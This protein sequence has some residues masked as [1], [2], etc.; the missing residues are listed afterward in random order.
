MLHEDLVEYVRALRAAGTDLAQVEAKRAERELPKSVR[1]TLSAFSNTPGGG[2]LILGLDEAEGFAATGVADSKKVRDSLADLA[3][4]QMAPP[5][6]P[7]IEIMTFEG[8]HLVVAEV[9]E[10]DRSAKP[11]YYKGAG[12]TNGAFI[13]VGD[14]DYRLGPAEVHAMVAGRGQPVDD[15]QPVEEAGP[16]DLLPEIVGP[17]LQRLRIERPYAYRELNDRELLLATR[18]LVPGP[19]GPVPSLAGLLCFGRLPQHLFPQVEITFVDY[20]T[21]EGADLGTGTRFLDNRAFDGPIPLLV[22][23]TL[24]RLVRTVRRS[25]VVSAG[26]GASTVYE[27]PI[28]AVREAVVN[29]VVHRDLGPYS[30]GTQVQ[31]EVYPDRITVRNP[32]GLFGAV[33]LDTL[34]E[35]GLSSSRNALLL[36]I[37]EDVEIP[38]EGRTV[39]ENRA[40]GIRTM[41]RAMKAARLS[42]PQFADHVSWFEVTL[43]GPGANL[44]SAPPRDRREPV[45]HGVLAPH[46]RARL[47][48]GALAREPL[49]RREIEA[50]TGLSVYHVRL[51]LSDLINQG[52]VRATGPV[53]SPYRRYSTTA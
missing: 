5:L 33:R 2:V 18:V 4:T 26:G 15:A 24:V 53:K 38:G 44:P 8:A 1:E 36:K 51:A 6:A 22:R 50:V 12:L 30:L 32:G 40:S 10:L 11:C 45:A 34:G 29:A 37:L 21:V 3:R 27:Y 41:V 25:T 17:F 23:E 7:H 47:V 46:E 49:S 39:C 35:P 43:I 13:R 20:P 28:E 48:L 19:A 14:G 52:V 42:P 16:D 9:A 31:V